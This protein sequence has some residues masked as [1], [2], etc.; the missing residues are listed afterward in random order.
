MLFCPRLSRGSRPRGKYLAPC[1]EGGRGS[2]EG[3]EKADRAGKKGKT[4]LEKRVAR[5]AGW[6]L[7]KTRLHLSRPSG[8]RKYSRDSRGSAATGGLPFPGGGAAPR[9]QLPAALAR[10]AFLSLPPPGAKLQFPGGL[11]RSGLEVGSLEV[12]RATGAGGVFSEPRGSGR[13]GRGAR[14]AG[15]LDAQVCG[16]GAG[17]V[18]RGGG[19]GIGV[20]LDPEGQRRRATGLTAGCGHRLLGAAVAGLSSSGPGRT[21]ARMVQLS[22]RAIPRCCGRAWIGSRVAVGSRSGSDPGELRSGKT[23]PNLSFP[24]PSNRGRRVSVFCWKV[25]WHVEIW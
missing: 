19:G 24:F 4:A 25:F 15:S 16:S 8:L 10:Q 22:R 2:S 12:T 1:G 20:H 3:R 9:L 21:R 11:A 13:L 6:S 5:P 18:S 23:A 17:A 7:Q 14:G